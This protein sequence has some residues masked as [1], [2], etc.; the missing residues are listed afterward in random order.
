M[1]Q[2]LEPEDYTVSLDEA[3]LLALEDITRWAMK[4][5]LVESRPMPNYLNFMKYQHLDAVLPSA[6][7]IV[8]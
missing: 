3:M 2:L 4:K 6:V 7:T 1:V 5:G 8:R